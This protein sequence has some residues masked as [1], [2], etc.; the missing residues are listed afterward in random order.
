M[1]YL[2][3]M[4][5]YGRI[6]EKQQSEIILLRGSG[7]TWG[8]CNYC[9][10]CRDKDTDIQKNYNLNRRVIDCIKGDLSNV[11]IICSGSFAE[12]D[13]QTLNYLK[14][15]LNEKQVRN[16]VL[17]GHWMHRQL[18]PLMRT[19]F[20][21]INIE[22][23]IGTETFD[24]IYREIIMNKGMGNASPA[25]IAEHFERT[26]IMFGLEGQTLDMLQND[27]E[28]ALKYFNVVS[29]NIFTPNDTKAIRDNATIERFY[30]SELYS[31]LKEN[32]R[33]LILDDLRPDKADSFDGVGGVL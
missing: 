3:E 10:Y 9:D 23:N 15:K 1:S 14:N 12:L 2:V 26:N 19:I 5:R 21:G 4:K 27:M 24:I 22:F 30:E 17:E 32:K 20:A 18:I 31:K 16:I 7:C 28:T 33:V 6:T 11:Q 8:R 25:D 13:L 29:L